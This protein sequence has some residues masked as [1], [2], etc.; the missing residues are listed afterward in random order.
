MTLVRMVPAGAALALRCP[1]CCGAVWRAPFRMHR[2]C[3]SALV[4]EREL[5]ITGAM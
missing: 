3:P 1:R 4:Y 2:A 5:G